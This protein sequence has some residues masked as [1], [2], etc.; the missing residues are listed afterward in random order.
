MSRQGKLILGVFF[1]LVVAS[2]LFL[3]R[4]NSA[5]QALGQPGL[6]LAAMELR[7]EDSQVVRTNGV[8]LPAQVFD[9]TS[10]LS[11][12]T[13]LELEWLPPD[14]TYGRRRYTFPDE[15]W[16]E[17]SVVLMG[18]DRTSIHKPEYCLPGQGFSIDLREV[19]TI[20]ILQ[21]HAYDLPVMKLTTSKTAHDRNGREVPLR[22]VYIYW[23]V[24][25]GKLATRH[26]DRMWMMTKGLLSEGELQRWAY[27]TYFAICQP[28]DEEATFDK[29]ARFIAESVPQFQTTTGKPKD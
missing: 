20:P 10:S 24:A 5:G 22:G 2:A 1:M 18:Q 11:P 3:A 12:V 28:G 4:L 16:I 25:D 6:R 14:T 8:A 7:N 13:K 23:F 21:P 27:V 26:L 29:M 9:C 19:V 17:S 15:T